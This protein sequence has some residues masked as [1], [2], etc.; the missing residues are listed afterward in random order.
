VPASEPRAL[1]VRGI[2]LAL[3]AACS[4]VLFGARSPGGALAVIAGSA[5]T[6]ATTAVLAGRVSKTAGLLLVPSLAWTT[7]A[8]GLNPRVWQLNE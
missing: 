1:A 2:Q 8:A 3:N 7:S 4:A 6:I 5:P